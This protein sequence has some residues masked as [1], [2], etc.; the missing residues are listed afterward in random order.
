[1]QRRV[2]GGR[3]RRK[4]ERKTP[5]RW[6]QCTWNDF[7]LYNEFLVLFMRVHVS[8]LIRCF[9]HTFLSRS[10]KKPPWFFKWVR[11]PTVY[12]WLWTSADK[13]SLNK[14]IN[15]EMFHRGEPLFTSLL[16]HTPYFI[17]RSS[18]AWAAFTALRNHCASVSVGV[19]RSSHIQIFTFGRR[20]TSPAKVHGRAHTPA[21][22][23]NETSAKDNR[24]NN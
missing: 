5:S 22:T 2:R 12:F 10:R 16:S 3:R 18:W 19:A 15:A 17:W 4:E 13:V 8:R 14:W 9:C 7:S 21:R 20:Q 24:Q 23:R 1:M 6:R 11:V